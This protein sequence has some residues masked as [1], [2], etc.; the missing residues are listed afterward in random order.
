MTDR[1]GEAQALLEEAECQMAAELVDMGFKPTGVRDAKGSLLWRASARIIARVLSGG[2]QAELIEF[3]RG[4]GFNPYGSEGDHNGWRPTRTAIEFLRRALVHFG[5]KPEPVP[6]EWPNDAIYRLGDLVQKKGRSKWRG[7]IVGWYR[8]E[9]TDLGYA[10]ESA[11]E[12]GSV[13]I[14]PE[15]TLVGWDGNWEKPFGVH[16]FIGAP[17]GREG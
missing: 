6:P 11:F 14:Y 15:A 9:L 12:A 4:E 16:R 8:T 7:R 17:T 5:G 13:Q 2:E 1:A 10:V 3:F